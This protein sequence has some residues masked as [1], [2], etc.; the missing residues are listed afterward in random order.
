[1]TL[2]HTRQRALDALESGLRS[3]AVL[4]ERGFQLLQFTAEELSVAEPRTSFCRVAALT[5]AKTYNLLHCT[6]SLGL[7]G[8]AQEAGAIGRVLVESI[9]LLAYLNADPQ[10]ADQVVACR[11]P[12]AGKR[13]AK[14]DAKSRQ[15][16]AYWNKH[17][18]H[19]SA[20][21]ES[22]SHIVNL[23]AGTII[24]RQSFNE[25]VLRR[26]MKHVFVFLIWGCFEAFRALVSATGDEQEALADQFE[27]LRQDGL[28]GFGISAGIA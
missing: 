15:L 28:R 16:R 24:V 4:I 2:W 14:I 25:A 1:M 6:Y 8:H 3:E 9:E 12:S 10:R 26:V 17:A 11:L 13:A 5:C 18:S 19:F 23:E 22:L 21:Y 20:S 27:C 7:D